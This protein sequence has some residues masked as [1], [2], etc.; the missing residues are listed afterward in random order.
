MIAFLNTEGGTIF[1]GVND[2]GSLNQNFV[3]QNQDNHLLTISSW[4]QDAF[5]PIPSSFV[6]F[7]YNEDNVLEIQIKEGNKKPYYLKEKGPKPSGVYKRVGTSIRKCNEDEILKLIMESNH[8]DFESDISENQCLTFKYYDELCD[9]IK[10]EN[11]KKQKIS[12]G[13]MKANGTYTNLGL[14]ISDQSPIM[15]KIA[16]Y[17]EHMNFK[18]KKHLVVHY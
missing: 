15:V 4:I 17:D 3:E 1:V 6:D 9:E 13:L 18:I 16:E 11:S 12:L 7:G 10:F 8:Y 14:L 5:Y 2:D